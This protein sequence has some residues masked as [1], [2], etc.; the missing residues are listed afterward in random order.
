MSLLS[1]K[2]ADTLR[3]RFAAALRD[4]VMLTLFIASEGGLAV[5]GAECE[6]CPATR[7]LLEEVAELD[8]RLTLRVRS[9][10]TDTEAAQAA[11]VDRVPA[12]IIGRGTEARVRYYGLP[13]GFE[14]AVLIEDILAASRGETGLSPKSVQALAVLGKDVHIQVFVTPTC[15]HCPRAALLAHAMAMV[16][17]RVRADVVEAMEFPALAD[18]YGVYGV[19]KVVINEAHSF[20]GALPEDAFLAQVLAAAAG[21]T[22]AVRSGE[23]P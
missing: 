13:S 19:P 22:A 9:L 17:P 23:A 11:G 21:A 10:V 6:Y 12:I 18:R 14:F 7:Q 4:N 2:D 8:P 3:Q 5:P 16:S 20:E 15:P 1:T